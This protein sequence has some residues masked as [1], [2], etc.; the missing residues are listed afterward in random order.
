M[1]NSFNTGRMCAVITKEIRESWQS[2]LLTWASIVGIL[3]I[4]SLFKGFLL[5]H[6][7]QERFA[8]AISDG[9]TPIIYITLF[10][11]AA[12]AACSVFKKMRSKSMRLQ[13]L[14]LPASRS[15]KYAAAWLIAIPGFYISYIAALYASQLFAAAIFPI[16]KSAEL[17]YPLINW[18]SYAGVNLSGNEIAYHI[19][20]VL[21]I[22]SFFLLGGIVW[23][24]NPIIKTFASLTAIWLIY[25]L[26]CVWVEY[27][28]FS[29][30]VYFARNMEINEQT[31]NIILMV[32]IGLLTV[33]NYALA[34][35]RLR[36][37][38]IINRW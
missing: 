25:T 19:L 32:T 23:A 9:L 38:E 18:F 1:N 21:F 6:Y 28:T 27:M 7:D 29:N 34:Y 17:S 16:F 36:E 20:G 26:A 12:I 14:M 22:Q 15:E 33:F 4:V 2:V 30:N 5:Q 24:K 10:V 11:F 37:A 3:T 8:A 35:L 13:A 31:V